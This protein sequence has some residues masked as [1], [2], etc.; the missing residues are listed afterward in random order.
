MSKSDVAATVVA[1]FMVVMVAERI[2]SGATSL[3]KIGGA[4]ETQRITLKRL[5]RAGAEQREAI[6]RL[7]RET[8]QHTHSAPATADDLTRDEKPAT[9]RGPK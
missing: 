7:W 3:R 1:A 8:R 4:L 9:P 2:S 6:D 5:E